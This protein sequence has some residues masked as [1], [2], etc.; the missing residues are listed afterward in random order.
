MQGEMSQ[1]CA[2]DGNGLVML[3]W[4]SHPLKH[5]PGL[6]TAL[7]H[8]DHHCQLHGAENA[9]VNPCICMMASCVMHQQ[10]CGIVGFENEA[11]LTSSQQ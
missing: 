11:W 2:I 4:A 10:H 8:P 9:P 1:S 7:H 5:H 3:L 6:G